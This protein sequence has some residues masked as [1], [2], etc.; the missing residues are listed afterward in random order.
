MTILYADPIATFG[1]DY[2]LPLSWVRLFF[3]WHGSLVQRLLFEIWAWVGA[4]ALVIALKTYVAAWPSYLLRVLAALVN[5]LSPL[6]T[7]MLGF[8]TSTIYSRWW[9]ART[10]M[11]GSAQAGA[12][13]IAMQMT[14]FVYDDKDPVTA[15]RL[16]QRLVRWCNLSFAIVLKDVIRDGEHFYSSYERMEKVG[17]LT[18]AE[19]MRVERDVDRTQWTLPLMWAGHTLTRLRDQ[20]GRFGVTELVHYMLMLQLAQLRTG[21]GSMYVLMYVPVPLMYRQLVSGTVRLYIFAVVLLAGNLTLLSDTSAVDIGSYSW[22]D[23]VYVM[24]VFFVYIGWLHV[25]D[26]L[27]NPYRIAPDGLDFD[28]YLSS[29]RADH[30]TMVDDNSIKLPTVESIADEPIPGDPHWNC[31]FLWR[32]HG[33]EAVPGWNRYKEYMRRRAAEAHNGAGGGVHK[34]RSTYDLFERRRSDELREEYGTLSG[35]EDETV[36]DSGTPVG[37]GSGNLPLSPRPLGGQTRCWTG[38][39]SRIQYLG[40]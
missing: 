35:G 12:Y 21:L 4:A 30:A 7:F 31:P 32:D 5:V 1:K 37:S 13:N 24:S 22:V 14:Q 8:Y 36:E 38:P 6:L 19:R 40:Y 20:G 2:V 10:Q 26:E 18:S 33:Y 16:K 11:C 29:Q 34:V 39:P 27:A 3:Y 15:A 25:A 17:L 9:D 23:L 28:D